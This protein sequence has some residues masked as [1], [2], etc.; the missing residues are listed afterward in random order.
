MGELEHAM[1][2]RAQRVAAETRSAGPNMCSAGPDVAQ[3][4]NV[5]VMRVCA[6]FD[7]TDQLTVRNVVSGDARGRLPVTIVN[8]QVNSEGSMICRQRDDLAGCSV[9]VTGLVP[10]DGCVVPPP[11]PLWSQAL[12]NVH[13][14]ISAKCVSRRASMN[15]CEQLS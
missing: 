8:R 9:R 15:L 3:A 10:P 1:Q 11:Q 14:A 5:Q 12:V 4:F 7:Q 6:Q 2:L 13:S